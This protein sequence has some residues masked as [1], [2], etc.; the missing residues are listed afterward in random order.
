[1]I[2]L[3]ANTIRLI[4]TKIMKIQK[5]PKRIQKMDLIL[6]LLKIV[7]DKGI[8]ICFLCGT[9]KTPGHQLSLRL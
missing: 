9:E 7:A 6:D 2:N 8:N 1:M 5:V 3:V 4:R